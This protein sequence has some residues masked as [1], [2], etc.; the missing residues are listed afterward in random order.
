MADCACVCV[1]GDG[2]VGEEGVSIRRGDGVAGEGFKARCGGR[3][4]GSRIYKWKHERD[5]FIWSS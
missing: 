2:G 4:A 1:A 3:G 5:H